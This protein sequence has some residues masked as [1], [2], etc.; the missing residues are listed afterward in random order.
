MYRG[1][2]FLK[3]VGLCLICGLILLACEKEGKTVYINTD[4]DDVDRDMVFF[5][6]KKGSL[7]DK[8][9]VDALYRGVVRGANGCNLMLSLVEF[10]S[11]TSKAFVTL[12][13]MLDYMQNDK[14]DRSALV[15]IAND[16]FEPVLHRYESLLT[17]A[18]NVDF[19]L[20][21]SSDTT[22]PIYT[23]RIP[24]YGVYYQ[25]GLLASEGLSD[26]DSIL[27]VSANPAEK[28]IAEM[29]AG[30]TQA[31][32]DCGTNIY[33][34]NTYLSET[35]GG[36]DEASYTYQQSYEIDKRFDL[37]VPLCGGTAQ[38]FYR[39]NRENPD[40]FYTLGV[41]TDMQLY[42]TRVPFSVVKHLENVMEDWITNWWLDDIEQ[43]QDLGL[44]SEAT[45]IV[46]ADSYKASLDGI[47]EKY[48]DTAVKKEKEY[49]G[50]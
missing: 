44:S 40:S 24:Q 30:F 21:E 49:E 47:A 43:H 12:E 22:L 13:Y 48:Y 4:E 45:G 6:S 25:A 16:N 2:K 41:D 8:G 9:Y 32:K 15:V 27:I 31:I 10:P 36:Y 19:L 37:V 50:R 20:C 35:S 38:G 7:G 46:V 18:Q 14:P 17:R 34:E 42:S 23:L 1:M 29:S 33:V 5:V 3:R 39:Y 26:V 28:S 11:D